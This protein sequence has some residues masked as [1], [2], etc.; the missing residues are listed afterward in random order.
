MLT[1]RTRGVAEVGEGRPVVPGHPPSRIRCSS[2]RASAGAGH[3]LSAGATHWRV[4]GG[5][6]LLATEGGKYP[7]D[8]GRG[9]MI[10]KHSQNW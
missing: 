5:L 7:V 9:S 8:P 10:E 2:I 4:G 6:A 3:V 1:G